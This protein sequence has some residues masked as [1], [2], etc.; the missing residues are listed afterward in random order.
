MIYKP[1]RCVNIIAACVILHNICLR[2][3]V[4]WNENE[5]IEMEHD[6]EDNPELYDPRLHQDANNRQA[7]IDVRNELIRT[8]FT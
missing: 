8:S 4:S 1:E 2:F 3:D 5:E 7:G 6:N